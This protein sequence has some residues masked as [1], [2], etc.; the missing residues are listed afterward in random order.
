MSYA[1]PKAMVIEQTYQSDFMRCFNISLQC[2]LQYAYGLSTSSSK[3]EKIIWSIEIQ[4]PTG[5]N[6]IE[7]PYKD[8]LILN[9]YSELDFSPTLK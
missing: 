7:K 9:C 3:Y 8:V 5:N 4:I 1:K 2:Y 6:E